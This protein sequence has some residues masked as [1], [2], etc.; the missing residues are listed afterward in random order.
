MA[1]DL[2]TGIF[3]TPQ[4]KGNK[5]ILPTGDITEVSNVAQSGVDELKVL[6]GSVITIDL[7]MPSVS[8]AVLAGVCPAEADGWLVCME[9]ACLR[10]SLTR[11]LFHDREGQPLKLPD[12]KRTL[13]FTFNGEYLGPVW[14][15]LSLLETGFQLFFILK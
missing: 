4:V 5:Y 8:S 6:S 14:L 15:I 3:L 2:N 7:E 13:L 1:S 12:T 10:L 11:L 9:S